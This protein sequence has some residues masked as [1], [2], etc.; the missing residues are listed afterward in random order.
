MLQHE[1]KLFWRRNEMLLIINGGLLTVMALIGRNELRL[2]HGGALYTMVG[3]MGVVVCSLWYF[4][5]KRSEEFY[6]L[7]HEQLENIEKRDIK[8]IDIFRTSTS[9]FIQG[10]TYMGDR[11]IRVNRIIKHIRIFQA[12]RIAVLLIAGIWGWVLV[13]QMWQ[14]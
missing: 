7:W 3:V 2:G 14:K 13:V 4:I 8:T 1:E 12:V 9:Y 5:S 11:E 6:D 10:Y